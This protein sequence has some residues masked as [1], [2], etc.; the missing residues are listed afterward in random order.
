MTEYAVFKNPNPGSREAV[1]LL[2]DIQSS[3]LSPLGTR[4]VVPLYRPEA[5]LG[6]VMSRLTPTLTFQGQTLVAMV[7][8]LAG[9]SR[10]ALGPAC[11]DLA[12]ARAELIQAVDL[13]L[14]GF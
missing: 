10:R 9:I 14:T 1:P 3:V 4:V 13:L 11:G 6:Q 12:A 5:V 8:E 2:L 7:P